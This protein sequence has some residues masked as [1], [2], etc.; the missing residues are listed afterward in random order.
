MTSQ[1]KTDPACASAQSNKQWEYILGDYDE[2]NKITAQALLDKHGIEMVNENTIHIQRRRV[3]LSSSWDERNSLKGPFWFR[4]DSINGLFV[5][6]IS[7]DTPELGTDCATLIIYPDTPAPTN[8]TEPK[9]PAKTIMYRGRLY[10]VQDDGNFN[11]VLVP[12]A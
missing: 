11:P 6:R 8:N 2:Y 10:L 9:E 1:L 7:N 5:M 12:V 3:K 4:F